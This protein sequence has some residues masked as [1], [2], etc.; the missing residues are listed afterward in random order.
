MRQKEHLVAIQTHHH[1]LLLSTLHYEDEIRPLQKLEITKS[2]KLAKQELSL[3]QELVD[4]LYKKKINLSTFKDTY[5]KK[6]K[7]ALEAKQAGKKTRTIAH[8]KKKPATQTLIQTLQ[9]SLKKPARTT[10]PAHY[11]RSPHTP[12]H[13]RARA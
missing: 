2:P 10:I 3:A 9:E 11:R 13:A 12:A 6:L 8:P 4:T 1:G 5:L 7:K